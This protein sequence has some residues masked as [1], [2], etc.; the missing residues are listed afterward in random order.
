MFRGYKPTHSSRLERWLGAENVARVSADMSNWYGPPIA[1]AGVPGNVFV[2]GDGDFIGH[3]REGFEC[4]ALDRARAL[5]RRMERAA[6]VASRDRQVQLNAGFGGLN[7]LITQVTTNNARWTL[8]FRKTS[9]GGLASTTQDH[10]YSTEQ[11]V[12][13]AVAAA[14]PNGSAHIKTNSGALLQWENPAS[15]KTT[16]LVASAVSTNVSGG[17]VLLYDRLHSVLKTMNSTVTEAVTGSGTRYQNSAPFAPDSAAGNFLYI[18][19]TSPVL[20]TAHNWTTC[21]YTS[22]TGVASQVLPSVAG[23]GSTPAA[24]LDMPANT[25]FCPLAAG[26]AGIQRLTQMQCSALLTTGGIDFVTA[27]P[28]AW[29]ACQVANV[30]TEVEHL[31]TSFNLVRIYDDA[32]LA[33]L[34]VNR[35]SST[36]TVLTGSITLSNG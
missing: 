9:A 21:T 32:C 34:D 14:A 29:F 22:A 10:W 30:V 7:N 3:C 18:V 19:C 20:A 23:N 36:A 25:W 24:R 5:V 1:L 11:P 31:Y 17:S 16:H 15:G 2:T 4:S 33:L 27:K 13:G 26:D 35:S 28:L 8:P 12:A 6:R